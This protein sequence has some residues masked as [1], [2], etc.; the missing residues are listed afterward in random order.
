MVSFQV[1]SDIVYI[2][3]SFYMYM[4]ILAVQGSYVVSCWLLLEISMSGVGSNILLRFPQ[5][6][7]F[8]AIYKAKL[9]VLKSINVYAMH[10]IL[11]SK[12]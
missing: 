2:T 6:K 11:S 5:R 4:Y 10:T 7:T 9:N 3:A 8:G 1:S 12:A